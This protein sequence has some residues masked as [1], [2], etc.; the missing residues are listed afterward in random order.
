MNIQ[1]S[2]G[3]FSSGEESDKVGT[4]NAGVAKP[5]EGSS[6][7]TSGEEGES[8]EEEEEEEDETKQVGCP[9]TTGVPP[10]LHIQLNFCMPVLCTWV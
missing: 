2:D 6:L 1:E 9:C 3:L 10:V 8:E 7:E 5:E 4:S